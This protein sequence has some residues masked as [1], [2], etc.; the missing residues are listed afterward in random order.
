MNWRWPLQPHIPNELAIGEE[1]RRT[2]FKL[3]ARA[4]RANSNYRGTYRK[5]MIRFL[6]V[7]A[8]VL[9]IYLLYFQGVRWAGAIVLVSMIAYALVVRRS[10]YVP[11]VRLAMCLTGYENCL[12]CGYVL[13]GL[14]DETEHCP[15]CGEVR[16]EYYRERAKRRIEDEARRGKPRRS[17]RPDTCILTEPK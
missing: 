8:P 3:A 7:A 4:R 17:T 9:A 10:T 14:P 16:P 6:I 13:H 11:Y 1:D 12:K 5:F 15:E 2:I